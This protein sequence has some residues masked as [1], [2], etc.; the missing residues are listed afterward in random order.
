MFHRPDKDG[1]NPTVVELLINDE[2][3]V[4]RCT[5]A[6]VSRQEALQILDALYNQLDAGL[7]FV[8]I[9]YEYGRALLREAREI[10]RAARRSTPDGFLDW[11]ERI[12]QPA[13]KE[14]ASEVTYL[15]D[16]D[17][18]TRPTSDLFTLPWFDGWF[19]DI[20]DIATLA[21]AAFAEGQLAPKLD[22]VRVTE[23]LFTDQVR[24]RYER[25]LR[26]SAD[27]LVLRAKR[28]E[29]RLALLCAKELASDKP[30]IECEFAL[31][32][33]ERSLQ[34]TERVPAED[35]GDN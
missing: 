1:G 21:A 12:G 17:E 7:A 30:A 13:E 32:L 26:E 19:Y 3:G 4:E 10:N 34:V 29:A 20:N 15:P 16:T 22:K 35:A 23:A 2:T 24:A 33:A 14:V 28:D 27:V 25:R 6:R 5:A 11:Y 18:E 9:G 31:A 8:V